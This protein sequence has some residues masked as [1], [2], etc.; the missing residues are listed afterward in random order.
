[1]FMVGPSG[2]PG[3]LEPGGPPIP[4]LL[5]PVRRTIE[6]SIVMMLPLAT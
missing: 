1:M 6:L 2:P 5:P 3:S 4:S